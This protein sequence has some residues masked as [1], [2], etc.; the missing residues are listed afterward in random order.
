M[1]TKKSKKRLLSELLCEDAPVCGFLPVLRNEDMEHAQDPV[2]IRDGVPGSLFY[3][4]DAS[5]RL[6][7]AES[8]R[9]NLRKL[10]VVC[11]A[12]VSTSTP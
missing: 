4:R 1:G 12:R 8:R 7:P 9:K 2:C 5:R 10:A 6:S 3:L 11:E